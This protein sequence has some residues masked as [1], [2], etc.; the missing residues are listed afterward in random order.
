MIEKLTSQMFLSQ[1][2]NLK[3]S[4]TTIFFFLRVKIEYLPCVSKNKFAL[5]LF[6]MHI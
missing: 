3:A 4:L 1:L 2:V 5:F 6:T